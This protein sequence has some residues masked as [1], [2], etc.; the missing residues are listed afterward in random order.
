MKCQPIHKTT[1]E[2]LEGERTEL[3]SSVVKRVGPG[4]DEPLLHAVSCIDL[5]PK[6]RW[7]RL[8]RGLE[9]ASWEGK[10]PRGWLMPRGQRILNMVSVA[11]VEAV[12]VADV[13]REGF[14]WRRCLRKPDV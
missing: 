2:P 14:T 3:R 7:R 5:L 6:W 9:L 13:A 12:A 4:G 11:V 10:A 1:Y 8:R